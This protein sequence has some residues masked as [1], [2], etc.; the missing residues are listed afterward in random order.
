[1]NDSE[2]TEGKENSPSDV[3]R[4]KLFDVVI[5]NEDEGINS[6]NHPQSNN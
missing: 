6:G 2:A 5:L 4:T 3:F 1:V